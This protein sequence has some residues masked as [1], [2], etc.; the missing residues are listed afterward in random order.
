MRTE[1]N[2]FPITEYVND[3]NNLAQ[4]NMEVIYLFIY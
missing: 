4:Y 2:Y 1:K 3:D